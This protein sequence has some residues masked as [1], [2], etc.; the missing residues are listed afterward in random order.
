MSAARRARRESR[1]SS[2]RR[3][4]VT[5][6]GEAVTEDSPAGAPGRASFVRELLEV[7]GVR[8]AVIGR[9]EPEDRNVLGVGI[10]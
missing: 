7:L 9:A 6:L 5:S 4:M 10:I 8:V 1:S 3:G 2:H